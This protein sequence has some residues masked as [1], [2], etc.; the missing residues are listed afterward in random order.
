MAGKLKRFDGPGIESIYKVAEFVRRNNS[1]MARN[2]VN[3]K[4]LDIAD[5][6]AKCVLKLRKWMHD[7]NVSTEDLSRKIGVTQSIV[8]K[9]T[10]G[11]NRPTPIYRAKIQTITNGE[12]KSEE[13]STD[14]EIRHALAVIDHYNRQKKEL[15]DRGAWSRRR[16]RFRDGDRMRVYNAYIRCGMEIPF[17]VKAFIERSPNGAWKF[18]GPT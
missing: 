12:I 11:S 14:A 17:E 2:G 15:E 4:T 8:K 16:D 13:W 5:R 7:N 1:L 9:W 10:V 3:Q 6:L 18:T